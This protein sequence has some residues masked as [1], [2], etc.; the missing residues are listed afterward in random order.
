MPAS[1]STG[2]AIHNIR[3]KDTEPPHFK[4]Q[5]PLS[6]SGGRRRALVKEREVGRETGILDT[7]PAER[8]YTGGKICVSRA[9]YNRSRC[10]TG[11]TRGNRAALAATRSRRPGGTVRVRVMP[12][13]LPATR[14]VPRTALLRSR[15]RNDRCRRGVTRPD[16]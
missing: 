13:A 1:A 4:K 3:L 15:D 8:V 9:Q 16:G 2:A 7:S 10:M 11:E 14:T 5:S 6:E 12:G